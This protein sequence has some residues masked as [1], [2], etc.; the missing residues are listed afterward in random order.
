MKGTL[1]TETKYFT[2]GSICSE[3][4]G[5]EYSANEENQIS[6]A[7]V[8]EGEKWKEMRSCRNIHQ[9]Q[10]NWCMARKNLVLLAVIDMPVCVLMFRMSLLDVVCFI[11][12]IYEQGLS[13]LYTRPYGRLN[14]EEVFPLRRCI[15]TIMQIERTQSMVS[16]HSAEFSRRL[17][18]KSGLTD[19]Y[20]STDDLVQVSGLTD[21]EMQALKGVK[22]LHPYL[23]PLPAKT[24]QSAFHLCK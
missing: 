8:R 2:Q 21:E 19:A 9:S 23:T 17:I 10:Q 4:L 18:M 6:N 3:S 7:L 12:P 5:R 22:S 24:P 20:I 14:Q 15:Q 16:P 1:I 13:S 11:V